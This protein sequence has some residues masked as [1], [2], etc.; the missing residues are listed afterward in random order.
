MI[1]CMDT[2]ELDRAEI[3]LGSLLGK[4]ESVLRNS[5]LSQSRTTLMTNRV[6]AL[7]TAL[8]LIRRAQLEQSR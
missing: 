4:C 7:R 1:H 6:G 3:E 5:T 2:T 8:E